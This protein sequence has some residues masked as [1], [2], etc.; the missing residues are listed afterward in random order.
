[1][2][3]DPALLALLA[4]EAGSSG[5]VLWFADEPFQALD[6][7]SLSQR[8]CR[9]ISNRYDITRRL[10]AAGIDACFSDFEVDAL[11]SAS[12]QRV[13]YRVSKEKPV[14]HHLINSA[15]RLLTPDGELWLAGA[16]NEGIK[17]TLDKASALFGGKVERQKHGAIHLGRLVKRTTTPGPWLD[18]RDYTRLRPVAEQNG[19]E[20]LSKPGQFGWDKIDR[21]SA[22]LIEHLEGFLRGFRQPPRS[23]L[24]LGCGYG[25]LALMA[26]LHGF[27]RIVAT[28][29]AAA[30]LIACRANF[31]RRNISGEVVADDCGN[32]LGERFE[33]ILCN[34]PFHRG[35][36]HERELTNRFLAA[37][38]RLLDKRGRALFVVNRFIPL[39]RLAARHFRGIARPVEVPGFKLIELTGPRQRTGR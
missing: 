22:L 23:L 5:S 21:G 17:T 9:V 38:A 34:P 27:E 16:R 15:W 10:S 7:A 4:Q 2:V 39:E 31:E 12:Q 8:D 1:M 33:A 11:P 26:S 18:D 28:D 24:D 36:A 32:T 25:Y 37:T 35:F 14:V 6:L 29:N 30:A 3:S 19:I 13:C 20:L